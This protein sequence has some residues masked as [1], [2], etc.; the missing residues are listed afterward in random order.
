MYATRFNVLT[1][2]IPLRSRK[3]LTMNKRIK[4][5]VRPR[6]SQALLCDKKRMLIW[7]TMH[8]T[9]LLII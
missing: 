8:I 1:L 9:I 4:R 5:N 6:S 7:H 3:M 2:D